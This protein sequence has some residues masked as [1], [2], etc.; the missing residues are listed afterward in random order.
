[1]NHTIHIASPDTSLA[2]PYRNSMRDGVHG[3]GIFRE[4]DGSTRR[5]RRRHR[6]EVHCLVW[7]L[8]TITSWPRG[9]VMARLCF[10]TLPVGAGGSRAR[11]ATPPYSFRVP[12]PAPPHRTASSRHYTSMLLDQDSLTAILTMQ[13]HDGEVGHEDRHGRNRVERCIAVPPHRFVAFLTN[14]LGSTRAA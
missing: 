5:R 10:S 1:M 7:N 9:H 8:E 13:G 11:S 14:R 12:H 4:S 6:A 2:G 3:N